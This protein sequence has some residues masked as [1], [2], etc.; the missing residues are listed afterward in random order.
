MTEEQKLN[1]Q[2]QKAA[3]EKEISAMTSGQDMYNERIIASFYNDLGAVNNEL[4]DYDEAIRCYNEALSLMECRFEDFDPLEDSLNDGLREIYEKKED[5]QK[6]IEYAQKSSENSMEYYLSDPEGSFTYILDLC[7]LYLKAG[8]YPT[9]K[10]YLD[11]AAGF[12]YSDEEIENR[13]AQLNYFYFAYYYA[14]DDIEKALAYGEKA[15]KEVVEAYGAD[16]EQAQ[17]V[18]T[19]LDN[20][21]RSFN[22]SYI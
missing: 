19:E 7:C 9:A 4:E 2:K 17:W 20:N 22:V 6:A 3:I 15:Y 10:R 14:T 8:D 11:R 12:E 1:L 18:K 5:Y 16:I 21:K 13:T